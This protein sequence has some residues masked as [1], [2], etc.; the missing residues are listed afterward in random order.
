M[1]SNKNSG[2]ETPKKPKAEKNWIVMKAI[3]FPY[4]NF[5]WGGGIVMIVG[6]LISIFRRNKEVKAV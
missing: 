5:F 4:I 2:E 3:E 1:E 6:F